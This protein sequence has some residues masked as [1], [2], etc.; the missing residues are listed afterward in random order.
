MEPADDPRPYLYLWVGHSRSSRPAYIHRNRLLS[1]GSPPNSPQPHYPPLLPASQEPPFSLIYSLA[2]NS[3]AR[4]DSYGLLY[5]VSE[6][7]YIFIY[8]TIKGIFNI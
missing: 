1:P 7:Y 3:K 8:F 5:N 2:F 4:V 6:I